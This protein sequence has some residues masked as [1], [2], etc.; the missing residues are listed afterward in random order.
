MAR[1]IQY[2]NVNVDIPDSGDP[3]VRLIVIQELDSPTVHIIPIPAELAKTLG[4]KLI[5]PSIEVPQA[6]RLV[7][8][9]GA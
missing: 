4:Q 2:G 8:P 3:N 5:S 6:S 7:V 9:H 1:Q